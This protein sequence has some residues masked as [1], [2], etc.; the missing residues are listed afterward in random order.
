LYF[1]LWVLNWPST[2]GWKATLSPLDCF[3]AFSK[4]M[5]NTFV[6]I[7]FWGF[8]FTL[9]IYLYISLQIPHYLDYRNYLV[10][11]ISFISL[12]LVIF[13]ASKSILSHITW[14]QLFSFFWVGN[15][16]LNSGFCAYKVGAL[17]F[18]PHLQYILL[19]LFWR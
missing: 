14:A 6:C 9:L 17:P 18:E 5:L 12:S 2:I 3:Y 8:Y 16:G 1:Y 7:Y 19:L 13:F 10:S 11:L 4:N 15:L